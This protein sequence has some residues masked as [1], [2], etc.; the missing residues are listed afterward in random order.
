ME[1]EQAPR[2]L[3]IFTHQSAYL[4][5][6]LTGGRVALM[7]CDS[8]VTMQQLTFGSGSK[9]SF[10]KCESQKDVRRYTV[11]RFAIILN[12]CKQPISL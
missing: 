5:S 10:H 4:D 7:K 12:N 8:T 6:A 2:R 3:R 11:R 1:L 9:F